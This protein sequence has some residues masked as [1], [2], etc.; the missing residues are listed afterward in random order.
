M[1]R[2]RR[3][4]L[5]LAAAHLVRSDRL[6]DEGLELRVAAKETRCIYEELAEG[7]GGTLEVFVMSGGGEMDIM[8]AVDGP[9]AIDEST[10]L[11]RKTGARPAARVKVTS[12]GV[13]ED[14]FAS[15]THV[16]LAAPRNGPGAYEICLDNSG[17]RMTETRATRRPSTRRRRRLRART[18][19]RWP[20][21]SSALSRCGG[22]WPR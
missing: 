15:P 7:V 2:P 4:L 18:R 19:T 11:P 1:P 20:R 16:A 5:L 12:G 21:S 14:R 3:R 8:V 17:S 10:G 13:N 22:N 9:M 6:Q